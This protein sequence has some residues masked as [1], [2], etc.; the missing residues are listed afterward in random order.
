MLDVAC[1]HSGKCVRASKKH[2]G[3]AEGTWTECFS[4]DT[5]FYERET[6]KN[7]LASNQGPQ[8]VTSCDGLHLIA[9]L[10][11]VV[12][13]RISMSLKLSSN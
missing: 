9:S 12:E 11:R 5:P 6:S 2:L 1:A 10:F 13:D 7:K 3:Y 4:F 8:V